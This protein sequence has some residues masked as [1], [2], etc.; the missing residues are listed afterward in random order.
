MS[1]LI[2]CYRDDFFT[3]IVFTKGVPIFHLVHLN[4]ENLTKTNDF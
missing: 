1:Q 3:K 2:S 4:H